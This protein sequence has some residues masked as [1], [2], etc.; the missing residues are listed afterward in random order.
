MLA[1][2]LI[3]ECVGLFVQKLM[4]HMVQHRDKNIIKYYKR[5]E[6]NK[7]SQMQ[8]GG[9]QHSEPNKQQDKDTEAKERKKE[10]MVE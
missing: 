2:L 10:K 1:M 6:T 4:A 3:V 8:I 5:A 9:M 7:I